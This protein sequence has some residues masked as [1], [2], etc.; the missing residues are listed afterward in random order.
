MGKI[1]LAAK[2]THVPSIWMSE[3]YEKHKGIR[4]NAIQGLVEL[5]RRGRERGVDAY[6][7]IDCHWITN[8]GFHIN[9]SPRFEG[10]FT[11]GELPHFIKDLRYDFNGDP[12]LANLI[13]DAVRDAGFRSLAHDD[14][15]IAVEYGT[16]IPMRHMNGDAAARV[17]PVAANQF[18]SI[19]EG[20]RMGE[21]MRKAIEASDRTVGLLASG[22]MSHAFWPNAVS[23]AGIND[24][25]GEFN[26]Q[27][28]LRVLELWEKG[29]VKSFLA[30]LPEYAKH[31][32]GECAMIDTAMLFGALGWDAYAGTGEVIGEYFG[33][34]GTGQVNVDFELA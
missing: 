27:V 6:V 13:A 10:E 16:L 2:I 7:V 24:I 5:G 19:D 4:D 31:C 3:M 22:S 8:Q 25:N 15:N 21:A 28:D 17:I 29:E 34:S 26:R 14:R 23:E 11:S 9:A 18:A 12:K 30:M 32:Y 1:G 33:S 20:R